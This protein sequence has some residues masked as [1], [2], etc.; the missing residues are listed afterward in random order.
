VECTPH[1]DASDHPVV[2]K[3]AGRLMRFFHTRSPQPRPVPPTIR[4]RLVAAVA[5]GVVAGAFSGLLAAR[6]GAVPDLVYLLTAARHFLEGTNPYE[7]MVGAPGAP[8]PYDE[9]FYYPFTT[10]LA[11]VPLAALAVPVACALFF[12]LSSGLL[13]FLITADGLWR[14]HV[15]A[16]APFVTAAALSQ[17]SPLVMVMALLPAAGFLAVLKPNLGMA[18][19][20]YRPSWRTLLACA[21]VVGLSLIALPTWPL[22]W[23]ESIRR[24]V[25]ERHAHAAPVLQAGGFLLLLSALAWRQRAG[26]LLLVMS[27]V[28]QQLFF[29]DQ[30]LLWLIP[31]TRQESVVLTF[32]SQAAMILWFLL[33]EEGDLIVFSAYP[34]VMA[35]LYLPALILVLRH[36]RS[37]VPEEGKMGSDSI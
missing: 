4:S 24:N 29:Y 26:R 22:D 27:V 5:V 37:P 19:L 13:A 23:L 21:A 10:V 17:F 28:P 15:F 16:S 20:A 11:A 35:L 33:R 8:Q 9:P 30:I 32:S 2:T 31:R 6:P 34:F 25:S 18:L 14:L 36:W 12:G 3:E 1:F 7:V